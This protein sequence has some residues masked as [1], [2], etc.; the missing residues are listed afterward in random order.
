MKESFTL[1]QIQDRIEKAN[2]NEKSK[3]EKL[4]DKRTTE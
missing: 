1:S 3:S 2:Q 4:T